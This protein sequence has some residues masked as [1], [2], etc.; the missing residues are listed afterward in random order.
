[1]YITFSYNIPCIAT[2]NWVESSLR[3]KWMKVVLINLVAI[4]LYSHNNASQK[5]SQGVSILLYTRSLIFF[6][7]MGNEN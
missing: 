6:F 3:K 5:V 2:K 7:D 4:K 1:M